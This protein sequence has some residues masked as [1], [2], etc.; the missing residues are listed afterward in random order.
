VAS[1]VNA[2][3]AHFNVIGGFTI[4]NGTATASH[5]NNSGAVTVRAGLGTA[6]FA[7]TFNNL[8]GGVIDVATGALE[9]AGILVNAGTISGARLELRGSSQTTLAAG[10]TLSVGEVDLYDSALLTLGASATYSGSFVDASNG[11]NEIN[12]GA[13]TLTLKGLI[14]LDPNFGADLITGSGTLALAHAATLEGGGTLVVGGTAHLDIEA[15]TTVTGSL[16]I[17]DSSANAA[18]AVVTAAGVY[19]L[20]ADIGVS[21]GASAASTFTNAGLFEKTAGT[22]NSVVSVDF[23][24]NGTITV[25]SGTLEFL[26]GTLTNHGTI[27]G[28]VSFDGNGNEL[29][30]AAAA[31]VR[32]SAAPAH[33][34]G[35]AAQ[36]NAGSPGALLLLSQAAAMFGIEQGA[37]TFSGGRTAGPRE[38]HLDVLG[39]G[40]LRAR[41]V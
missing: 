17:G 10:S 35:S 36:R 39:V 11:N 4:G 38:A 34:P 32:R 7:T 31:A 1:V 25:T 26:K 27:N 23:V 21:R 29:I 19:D 16:E 20:T 30:T 13:S 40:H 8:A 3:A 24:N 18:R 5:F 15:K 2:R 28:T 9:N 33:A 41:P 37:T 6:T 22:G 14:D 12:L